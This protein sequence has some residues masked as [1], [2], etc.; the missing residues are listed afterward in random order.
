MTSDD[1]LGRERVLSAGI[2]L[3]VVLIDPLTTPTP[4]RA[5]AIPTQP[6]PAAQKSE[7]SQAV[8][9]A[10][11]SREEPKGPSRPKAR[12]TSTLY[13]GGD[14]WEECLASDSQPA[15]DGEG[16][17]RWDREFER[18]WTKSRSSSLRSTSSHRPDLGQDSLQSNTSSWRKAGPQ[19]HPEGWTPSGMLKKS[20][21]TSNTTL[22]RG[23]SQLI[24][25]YL[26]FSASRCGR[27]RT[28]ALPPSSV[29]TLNFETL[30]R[31]LELDKRLDESSWTDP[32]AKPRLSRT[33]SGSKSLWSRRKTAS[34]RQANLYI[35][36]RVQPAGNGRQ[37]RP[38]SRW[39][40]LTPWPAAQD[41]LQ[42]FLMTEF[43]R[44]QLTEGDWT[45][46]SVKERG[47]A[48]P[49]EDEAFGPSGI[50]RVGKGLSRLSWGLGNLFGNNE[51]SPSDGGR[52]RQQ[53]LQLDLGDGSQ[54]AEPLLEESRGFSETDKAHR[55]KRTG[56]GIF[57]RLMTSIWRSRSEQPAPS[58]Q[59]SECQDATAM[60]AQTD[61]ANVFAGEADARELFI[62][63]ITDAVKSRAANNT[64]TPSIFSNSVVSDSSRKGLLRQPLSRLSKRRTDESTPSRVTLKEGL[65]KFK[66]FVR[67]P[68]K[69]SSGCSDSTDFNEREGP[70]LNGRRW[71]SPARESDADPFLSTEDPIDPPTGGDTDRQINHKRSR[72]P[73]PRL[74]LERTDLSVKN[75]NVKSQIIQVPPPDG[76]I[77]KDTTAFHQ[78][79]TRRAGKHSCKKG[80]IHK[81]ERRGRFRGRQR[82]RNGE[83]LSIARLTEIKDSPK[84]DSGEVPGPVLAQDSA[85]PD[86][87]LSPPTTLGS[88]SLATAASRERALL[89][90]NLETDFA[91][92]DAQSQ[93][94]PPR[95]NSSQ[96]DDYFLHRAAHTEAR[97]AGVVDNYAGARAPQSNKALDKI[98]D[99]NSTEG[100]ENEPPSPT[101]LRAAKDAPKLWTRRLAGVRK[102]ASSSKIASNVS[103]S[104]IPANNSLSLALPSKGTFA[105]M[106]RDLGAPTKALTPT[107]PLEHSVPTTAN[108]L[109][110]HQDA[111]VTSNSPIR[112][113]HTTE[114]A[115][116]CIGSR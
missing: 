34:R 17:Q 104:S 101:V 14:D 46:L 113:A 82:Q 53:Y 41:T 12:Q 54:V 15:D 13:M 27:I 52:M 98:C 57:G 26:N 112:G 62:D 87:I 99:R 108:L 109:S 1:K 70:R 85:R 25:G 90:S 65:E 45:L 95:Q 40:E 111:G 11:G 72:E 84:Q 22:G 30:S 31:I 56:L 115:A 36:H 29:S 6:T 49:T 28:F 92:E 103:A 18:Q 59:K 32:K 55:N 44:R 102:S 96:D 69:R 94:I 89:N 43:F 7:S 9:E 47:E 58:S 64:T 105:R 68:F 75:L 16:L 93:E 4:E 10:N 97:L 33:A 88:G 83:V 80:E 106:R 107:W 60:T 79:P 23:S 73:V 77:L 86:I 19:P 21:T 8:P 5:M 39:S 74:L 2:P 24:Q 42:G 76:T 81:G 50:S 37:T 78:P 67:V 110:A 114:S 63:D 20:K 61:D 3:A 48:A 35:E 116:S 66:R 100:V 71:I 38:Y 51:W 91:G